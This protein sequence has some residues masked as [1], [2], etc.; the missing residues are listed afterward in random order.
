METGTAFLRGCTHPITRPT[1]HRPT[2]A[3]QHTTHPR[4][5]HKQAVLL[6]SDSGGLQLGTLLPPRSCQCRTLNHLKTPTP[7][8][9]PSTP[10]LHCWPAP[11]RQNR[12]IFLYRMP[13]C[14]GSPLSLLVWHR[15]IGL[16]DVQVE[17][18][19]RVANEYHVLYHLSLACS[20]LPPVCRSWCICMCENM[21]LAGE[22][23][24]VG[25]QESYR[26]TGEAGGWHF[27]P[28]ARLSVCPSARLYVSVTMARP[29]IPGASRVRFAHPVYVSMGISVYRFFAN[30]LW[31]CSSC[32]VV[33]CVG[34]WVRV[35]AGS[36][37]VC[38]TCQ[39][40]PISFAFSFIP[41]VR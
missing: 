23:M 7:D 24:Q 36:F 14:T 15:P 39:C 4:I 16:S 26:H 25:Q 10:L 41:P 35:Y 32:T 2:T 30:A 29:V 9:A 18:K 1:Y 3:L 11:S 37:D 22:A 21:Q 12:S 13:N 6:H 38:L 34:V 19:C 17:H 33:L 40:W 20:W 28:F 8:S 27:R 5:A 31:N